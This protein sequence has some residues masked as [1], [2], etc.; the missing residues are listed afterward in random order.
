MEEENKDIVIVESKIIEDEDEDIE[1]K[2]IINKDIERDLSLYDHLGNENCVNS[3]DEDN[4]ESNEEEEINNDD[5]NQYVAFGDFISC[6][7]VEDNEFEGF[8][9]VVESD[10][11]SA[12]DKDY[13]DTL[14]S[15][16]IKPTKDSE[17]L[18]S[19]F[20]RTI[21]KVQ[22]F[23]IKKTVTKT[24]SPEINQESKEIFRS[25]PPLTKKNID[26]IKNAMSKIKLTPRAS[27]DSLLNTILQTK[28]RIGDEIVD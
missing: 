12:L 24:I 2:S 26:T 20:N 18:A 5:N 9:Q 14:N 3:S 11:F 23:P 16:L 21:D 10:S 1:F 22:E 27:T 25:I 13:Y 7:D 19:I 17:E 8:D 6:D 28:P 15:P 4:Y